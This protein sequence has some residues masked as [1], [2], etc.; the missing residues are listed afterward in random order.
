[1]G[2]L[3]SLVSYKPEDEKDEVVQ[4]DLGPVLHQAVT[5]MVTSQYHLHHE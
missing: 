3:L 2:R 1:M 4:L 5:A